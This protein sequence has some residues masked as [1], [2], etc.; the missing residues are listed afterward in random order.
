MN[1][2]AY[3]ILK[4]FSL[5]DRFWHSYKLSEMSNFFYGKNKKNIISLQ[6]SAELT[7]RVIK[8]KIKSFYYFHRI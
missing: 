8:V 4:Y 1:N 6:M 3:K 5:D 2:T 7:Q